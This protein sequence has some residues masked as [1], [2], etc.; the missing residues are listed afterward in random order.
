LIRR[1]SA[2]GETVELSVEDAGQGMP[3]IGVRAALGLSKVSYPKQ[4]V[5]L[6][7]MRERLAQI[8]GHLEIESETGRTCIRATVRLDR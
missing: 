1:R 5:G 2:S 7:G 8:G 4:G 3:Q 6:A